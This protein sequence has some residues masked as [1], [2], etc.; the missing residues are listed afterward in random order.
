V[1]TFNL[2]TVHTVRELSAR[3]TAA[4]YVVSHSTRECR[5]RRRFSG[6]CCLRI[7]RRIRRH[8]SVRFARDV[9]F[10]RWETARNLHRLCRRSEQREP[11]NE[12]H[13]YEQGVLHDWLRSLGDDWRLPIGGQWRLCYDLD[14]KGDG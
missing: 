8:G 14:N 1:A 11:Q 5:N 2:E 12:L 7:E 10:N 13:G 4:I 3:L 9:S 6:S